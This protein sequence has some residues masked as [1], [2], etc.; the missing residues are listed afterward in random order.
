MSQISKDRRLIADLLAA[1]R[2][3][4]TP[5]DELTVQTLVQIDNIL[6]TFQD[7]E[8]ID[9]EMEEAL[10]KKVQNTHYKNLL[11]SLKFSFDDLSKTSKDSIQAISQICAELRIRE[12]SEDLILTEL[13]AL[14]NEEDDLKRELQ[15][16]KEKNKFYQQ[17]EE[18]INEM[19]ENSEKHVEQL[20]EKIKESAEYTKSIEDRVHD[21]LEPKSAEYRNQINY[22]HKKGVDYPLDKENTYERIEFLHKKMVALEKSIDDVTAKYGDI[23]SIPT[24]YEE[25]VKILERK[26]ARALELEQKLNLM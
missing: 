20:N 11:S 22:L 15:D 4:K 14:D 9:E 26:K 1:K 6:E 12:P 23:A 3:D 18:N 5:F 25:A 7:E 17:V 24:N 10:A 13:I 19:L 21:I 2:I 8:F 16:L